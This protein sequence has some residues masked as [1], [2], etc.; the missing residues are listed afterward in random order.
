MNQSPKHDKRTRKMRNRI[1]RQLFLPVAIILWII[2]W[3]MVWTG[4]RK[5][6]ETKRTQTKAAPEDNLTI[7]VPITS[8]EIEA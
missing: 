2:G 6:R 5:D 8:E 4:S 3:T 7:I 1:I